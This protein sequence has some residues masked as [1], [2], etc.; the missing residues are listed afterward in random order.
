MEEVD[1]K[2]IELSRG[3]RFITGNHFDRCVRG[4]F[5]SNITDCLQAGLSQ[6]VHKEKVIPVIKYELK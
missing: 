2:I 5:Y 4:D 1:I 3:Y 6:I